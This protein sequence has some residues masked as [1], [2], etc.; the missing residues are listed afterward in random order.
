M[1]RYILRFT[2]QGAPPAEDLKR[3][4]SLQGV[5]VVDEPSPHMLLVEATAEALRPLN[6][7]PSWVV[8]PERLLPMPDPRPKVRSW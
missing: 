4:R 5:T 2:G 8:T 1:G 6:E 3:I 7:L